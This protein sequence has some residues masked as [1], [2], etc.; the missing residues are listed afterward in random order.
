MLWF[1][2]DYLYKAAL[3]KHTQKSFVILQRFS[4]RKIYDQI[5][6]YERSCSECFCLVLVFQRTEYTCFKTWLSH[7]LSQVIVPKHIV[8]QGMETQS[9]RDAVLDLSLWKERLRSISRWGRQIWKSQQSLLNTV[10]FNYH[11][12]SLVYA[13]AHR[14]LGKGHFHR[15]EHCTAHFHKHEHCVQRLH[16]ADGR[17]WQEEEMAVKKQS[18]DRKRKWPLKQSHD[19]KRKHLRRR[20]RRRF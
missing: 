13:V 2:I 18:H 4:Y 14:V 8:L 20:M 3:E 16:H 17:R 9:F 1:D 12:Y 15:H 6:N 7:M 10:I 11:K 19:R 5:L